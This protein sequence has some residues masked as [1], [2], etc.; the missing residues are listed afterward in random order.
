DRAQ[1]HGLW[2][3]YMEE[4][5][6]N[7]ANVATGDMSL[8]DATDLDK[9]IDTF[10]GL[11]PTSVLFGAIGVGG[12]AYERYQNRKNMN[13]AFGQ[14]N[15]QQREQLA[16]LQEMAAGNQKEAIN[17]EV[18][19]FLQETIAAGNLTQEEKRAEIEYLFEF[20]K[21]N[22]IGEIDAERTPEE[23][24]VDDAE[25]SRMAGYDTT[26][27]EAMNEAKNDYEA[28]LADI[29]NSFSPES[30]A[31]IDANPVEELR[32]TYMNPSYSDEDRQRVLDYVNAKQRYDGMVQ[33][34]RDD[35]DGMIQA[36]DAEIDSQVN[37][38]TGMVQPAT[39]KVDNRQVHIID[40]NVT[41]LE[42]GSIDTANSTKDIIVRDAQTGKVE[43]VSPSAFLGVDEAMDPAALKQQAAENIR[44]TKAQQAVDQIDGVLPFQQGDTYD[45]VDA[46]GQPVQVQII[47]DNGDGTVNVGINGEAAG[48]PMQKEAVQQLVDNA[49]RA[50]AVARREEAASQR[51]KNTNLSEP[52][53]SMT[54]GR[55]AYSLNEE[56][57]VTLPDGSI[58]SAVINAEQ[59]ADGQYEVELRDEAGNPVGVQLL[60]ADQLNAMQSAEEQAEAGQ[61]PAPTKEA[62]SSDLN[63]EQ[64]QPA[65]QAAETPSTEATPEVV[66]QNDTTDAMPMIGE[67]E[68]MEPDFAHAT[69]QRTQQ[70][71]YEESGLEQ[72]EADD[73]VKD[74]KKRAQTEKT[75][76]EGKKPKLS[77]RGIDNKIP[78]FQRA[79]TEWQGKVDEAQRKVDYW[80]SVEQEQQMKQRQ[81]AAAVAEENAARQAAQTEQ[82]IKEEEARKAEEAA[83]AAEQAAVGANNVN[84]AIREKWNAAPKVEGNSDE[85][86]LAN[87]ERIPGRYVLV[88]SGAASASHN[89]LNGFLPTEGFPVDENG[90]SVN[91]RDYERDTD[92]QDITRRIADSYDQRALQTPVVVSSDGVVLSGNGRT[93]A[94]ELAAAQNTDQAYT[95]YL[96]SHPERFGFTTEQVSQMQHPRV[97]FV[98]DGQMPYTAETFGKFNQQELKGQSK[99]EQAVKLGKVVD[100]QTFGRI[101]RGIN[102]FDS[103]GAYYND[104]AAATEAVRDLQRAGAISEAQLPQ[105]FDGDTLSP[106]GR[107]ILENTLIGKAFEGNPDA[108]RMITAYKGMRQSV[109][110]ALSE[111]AN[112]VALGEEYSLQNELANAIA[113]VYEARNKGGFKAGERV[114]SFAMQGNLFQLDEGATVADFEDATVLMLA[115]VLNDNRSTQLKKIMT[116]YNQHAA[117]SASGQMDIFS[118]GVQ[119]KEDI[120]NFVRNI[121]NNGTEAE[122]Q[123]ALDQ[124]REQRKQEAAGNEES[125]PAGRRNQGSG[126]EGRNRGDAQTSGQRKGIV[127]AEDVDEIREMQDRVREW[128]S[129]DY[130]N[131]ARG[132]SREDIFEL[133]DGDTP[134]PIAYVPEE[135]LTYLSDGISDNRIYSS[136]G[137]FIDHAVN[138]HPSIPVEQYKNIQDVL[139]NPD[140]V[141]EIM[142][143]GNRSVVFIKKIDK[144]NAV[145]VQLEKSEDGKIIWHKS[146]FD[147]RKEPYKNLPDLKE[148]EPLG[149]GGIPISHTEETAPGSNR[150][151]TPNGS[152]ESKDNASSGNIQE[153]QQEKETVAKTE[154]QQPN[155]AVSTG[156][157]LSVEQEEGIMPTEP[158]GKPTVSE[159]KDN[160][161][162]D[163]I[164]EN[165]QE[166]VQQQ[167]EAARKEVAQNP[168]EAQKEA[169]NY[170][171]GHIKLD[172]YDISIENPKGSTRSGVDEQGKEWSVTMNN[173]YGYLRG[174]EGVD[175]D[176][177]DVFLSDEPT[178]GNVFVV[179]QVKPDGSFDEHKVMYGFATADEARAAYLANY[180][181]GWT[182]LGAITE[183]SKDE[184]K[185]WV[186]S[187]HRKTKPFAEYKSVKPIS[188]QNEASVVRGE[189]YTI[190]PTIYKKKSGGMLDMQLVKFDKLTPEQKKTL[191]GLARQMKG[192]WSREDEGFLMRSME[193]A[194]SLTK[195]VQDPTQEVAPAEEQKQEPQPSGNKLVTDARYEELKERMR[196]KL[197][198]QMN[199]GIDPEILTI[200]IEM[201]V[202]HIEK[203]SRKFADYAKAM[204]ADLGDAIRPYLKAFY[205]GARDLPEVE[206][207]GWSTEMDSADNVSRFDVANFD[208]SSI[209]AMATAEEVTKEQ[210]VEQQAE[211]AVSQVTSIAEQPKLRPATEEDLEGNPTVYYKG[212][213]YRIVMLMR[214]G[215]QVSA[216]EFEKPR[217]T[218]VVLTNMESVSP[219]ELMVEDTPTSTPVD[220]QPKNGEAKPKESKKKPAKKAEKAQPMSLDLFAQFEVENEPVNNEENNR[221]N[222]E[223]S[224]T[225]QSNKPNNKNEDGSEKDNRRTNRESSDRVPTGE[226]AGSR[227]TDGERLESG[228]QERGNEQRGDN[229]VQREDAQVRS[230][231]ERSSGRI[232]QLE[233]TEAKNTRNFHIER[234]QSL[235]PASPK[236]RYDANVAAIRK[237]QDL[238]ESGAEATPADKKILAKFSGWGGLGA[239]LND[240]DSKTQLQNLLGADGYEQAAMSANSAFYTPAGVIDTLW[241]VAKRLGFKGGN[242]LEGSAGIGDII[243]HMPTDMSQRSSIEAVEIDEVTGNILKLLYPDAKVN[244]Q[245]FEQTKIPNGSVDL[246]ITNVPFVTGLKVFDDSGDKDLSK[247]FGN[248][249]DFCIAK[250][251]RKLREGGIG[252]FITSS[253]TMDRSDAL[254]AWVTNEGGSDFIGAFRLNNKT[255]GGTSVTSDII[256]I[257]KRVNG[258]RAEQAI[259]VGDV[260]AERVVDYE[261]GETKRKNGK[262]VPVVKKLSMLYNNYFMEHPENMAGKMDFGFEHGDTYRPESAGLFPNGQD[263][264]KMLAEWLERLPSES[265]LQQAPSQNTD[266]QASNSELAGENTKEGQLISNSKGEICISRGGVA[267]PLNLNANKIKGHTKEECLQAYDKIKKALSDVLDYQVNNEDD[268]GLKPLLSALNKA[269]DDFVS[270]Y[271]YLNRNTS[272]SFLRNDVDFAS[273]AALE[274][275]E[276][277]GDK[278]GNKVVEVKKAAVF[279][280]RVVNKEAEPEPKS[281]SEA[282]TVSIYKHGRLDVPYMAEKLGMEEDV[283]RKEIIESGLGFE[284]PLTTEL[285]VSFEYLS[286]NVREKLEQAREANED[287]RYDKNIKALEKVIPADIP[288]HLIEFSIG[289]SWVDPK[290]YQDYVKD[291]TGKNVRLSRAGGSWAMHVDY[292]YS[293][294]N[295]SFGVRSELLKKVIPGTDLIDAAM[296]NKTITV[297]ETH[298]DPYTGETTTTIDKDA[299]QACANKIDE[300]RQD[301]KDWARAKMQSD[302]DLSNEISKVYNDKFNN[303][304]PRTIPNEFVPEHFVGASTRFNL[305][306]HQGKAAVRATMQ[307]VLLAHEVGTGKTFT[308]ITAAMEMRRLELAKKPMIVVQNATT[309]QFAASAKDLY[310]NAK[311]LTLDEADRTAEGRKNFYAKIKYNDWDMIIVPQSVFDRIP[312]SEERQIAYIQDKIAEKMAVMDE[313]AANDDSGAITRQAQKEIDAL[314]EE[315]ATISEALADKKRNKDEK[316]A[317]KTRQNAAVKARE[318]LDRE[319]DEVEN[320]DDMEIDA[321]LIDEAHE[322]KHLG[323]ATAMQRG[324]KGIDPS[325][326]KKA[327][328]AYL[329]IQAVKERKNG[330]NVVMATGTPISNTAAEIWTFMRYLLPKEQL[331]AYDIYYFDDFVRNFGNITQMLEFATNGRFK[332]NN[333]F[334][335]YSNLPELIRIWSGAADTVKTDE[336]GEVK[337][338]IPELETGKAQD[339]YLPQSRSLRAIMSAVKAELRRYDEMSGKEKKANSHIPLTMYGIAKAAA[340]DPRLVSDEAIDEPLSKTN[341]AV[342]ETL[343][344]LNDTKSYNGTVAIFCDN[345]QNKHTGFNLYEEIKRKLI[346]NGVPE[347]QIFIMRSGLSDKKKA[348]VFAKMNRGE[349]RVMLGS[350]FTLGTG[351]NIQERLHTLIH[352]DAPNRPMDY[353]QRNGRILRQGNLHRDWNK[354]VRVL[355]F[356]VEDSLDVT[357]YQRLKTKGAIADSVMNGK[358][359]M[360]NNQENRYI[361]EEEDVFGD[362]V[363]QL[364]GS[365]YAMLKNQAEKDY[366]KLLSKKQQHTADQIY[367]HNAIP[368]YEGQIKANKEI[369]TTIKAGLKKVEETFPDGKAK[370]ITVG[371]SKFSSIDGMADFIK[372]VVNKRLKETEDTLR[373]R[374][375]NATANVN[376]TVKVDGITFEVKAALRKESTFRNGVL[377]HVVHTDMTYDCEELGLE[378]VPVSRGSFRNAMLD[379]IGNVITGNDL[380]EREEAIQNSIER[381]ESELAQIRE[382]DGRPFPLEKELKAAEERVVDLTEKMQKEL[383]EKEAKYTEMDSEVEAVNIN[384]LTDAEEE[385]SDTA[386]TSFQVS[387]DTIQRR[388]QAQKVATNAV[389]QALQ[390]AGVPVQTVSDK[391]ALQMLLLSMNGTDWKRVRDAAEAG[392]RYGQ[393]RYYVVNLEDPTHINEAFYYETKDA[394]Q[395]D[396][397]YYNRLGWGSFVMLDLDSEKNVVSELENPERI[398]AQVE[399]LKVKGKVYG[400]TDGKTI[401][402]TKRGMNPNTTIHEYTHLWAASL[403]RT[404]PELWGQVKD[405]LRGTPVWADVTDDTNYRNIWNNEDA[406]ASEALSRISGRENGNYLTKLSERAVRENGALDAAS[407]IDRVRRALDF[408]WN[409]VG[410]HVFGMKEFRNI[411]QVTDRILYDLM[412]GEQ[413]TFE[414][415]EEMA[416]NV[417]P[418]SYQP[419]K[420]GKGYKVFVLKDGQLYPPMVANPNGAATPVG[421]WLEAHAA[422]VAGTSKTGR[423]QVKAGGKGTQGGSGTLAYRPGW[424]LGEIPYAKQFNRKDESGE[425][426]LFPNN[427]VW[428]EVEYANDVDYQEEARKEGTNENGKY[429][430]SLAGLKRV[431]ENGSYRYRTNPDPTT[432]EWIITGAMKVNRILTPSEVDAMVRAAGREPQKR[433]EGAVTDEQVNALNE[434]LGLAGSGVRFREIYRRNSEVAY[435]F[436]RKNKGVGRVAVITSENGYDILRQRGLSADKARE[437]MEEFKKGE[438]L[439]LYFYGIDL[440]VVFDNGKV[441]ENEIISYLWHEAGHR[442]IHYYNIPREWINEIAEYT[443]VDSPE[444]YEDIQRRYSDHSEDARNEEYTTFMLEELGKMSDKEIIDGLELLYNSEIPVERYMGAI[445]NI[446]RYGTEER[447]NGLLQETRSIDQKPQAV[448]MRNDEAAERGR[449]QAEEAI[450]QEVNRLADKLGVPV[451][452]VHSVSELPQS[453]SEARKRIDEGRMVK[454]WYN[455]GRIYVYVPNTE[456]AADAKRTMVHEIVAHYGLRKLL[457]KR[458]NDFMLEVYEHADLPIRQQIERLAA[459]Y[460]WD[461]VTATEE[462]LASLAETTNFD[463]VKRSG[464]WARIKQAF[465]RILEDMGFGRLNGKLT[466]NELRYLLWRSYD[467]LQ[468]ERENRQRDIFDEAADTAMQ[469]EL[470]V[471]DYLEPT[472]T[473]RFRITMRDKATVRTEYEK[474]V[475]SG[476]FQ[477][478]EAVQDSMRGLHALYKAVLGNG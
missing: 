226:S 452:I 267:E 38:G 22:A 229:S 67:G 300:I 436:A 46:E 338:K 438:S 45:G 236:A 157:S 192:W 29:E 132:L 467:N 261:T 225:S 385:D 316:R 324:V 463:E 227:S 361:E 340:I 440:I 178:E 279:N 343:R 475:Q 124:A 141:K 241:D 325:F 314:E 164:Q 307:P 346:A 415:G 2:A 55:D 457:G 474:M 208:K 446:I 129:E 244:V 278:K 247:R 294:K 4:V 125:V 34:V 454:G 442:V 28:A 151:S 61:Q 214:Q 387:E 193:D 109:V 101:L 52:S 414:Q 218:S 15:D 383:A 357:A 160:T 170:K 137:Y 145:V 336:A 143:D 161:S 398:A 394:A 364:S 138:H 477:F 25:E 9:N 167:I 8:K 90:Q 249:H 335:G 412:S 51:A 105:M 293:E 176:H 397:A 196:K 191:S 36:S 11:A 219:S 306:E 197:G 163:N 231:S 63:G 365:E 277:R 426:Q 262:E 424:H 185:K 156:S 5:Y 359:M 118:G 206:Q 166:N 234:G 92:A 470:G 460:D 99:S 366:K 150:L 455:N 289:S 49:R 433:Q 12:Y 472:E 429:Q 298:K 217:I 407:I 265:D 35:I 287:G 248:I 187:S 27:P 94:G 24:A 435:N 450:E 303:F 188:G 21:Q 50:Q 445:I 158:N 368:K 89:A 250:N 286:G 171:K 456:D 136:M 251:V 71:L 86:V 458:F 82:A 449:S 215:S 464:W 400:W 53:R 388:S 113:L 133:F 369:L 374:Y 428:A 377:T 302:P 379:I 40:G 147:Q 155:N 405:L 182:G 211:E 439:G 6:N 473:S 363:A 222:E 14:M 43:F 224:V 1:F 189:G 318:M 165:Q 417:A 32:L 304:V 451:T 432:D 360:N 85:M 115:D 233:P 272:I 468:R 403:Q 23:R 321:I 93:M 309:G 353:T 186:E 264:N 444:F 79:K 256:I 172:G 345:Y 83:K 112:N 422:P 311:V 66:P 448:E 200:G 69:P 242:V 402:L 228:L 288:A 169:G 342:E 42:D 131:Q 252:I 84:P 243:G 297:K 283:V 149:G 220:E 421:V 322:Y 140:S 459:R 81:A 75:K 31:A 19:R 62:V 201:A 409:W 130:L 239:F 87:G 126:N 290:L 47:S 108:V 413:L 205:N 54:E 331:Q 209:D 358:S 128:L 142:Q 237:M 284:N 114:S 275:Y 274:N 395:K 41:L 240:Y 184:F 57:G 198:G 13:R 39:L 327:Q 76:L 406:I 349:I 65:E 266:S 389:L 230:S 60:T 329:K 223:N 352:L 269:Y 179:D 238:M 273:I 10:L 110:T 263:Q 378:S 212:R 330:K 235:A 337:S 260:S 18:K 96:R 246:A 418:E 419:T 332:E 121:V 462:Y 153:N 3:E 373:S 410:T 441:S 313:I 291:R 74:M 98:P 216:T 44:Q 202:Y 127:S 123:A 399:F 285:E 259:N 381:K 425:K 370:T 376:Y 258:Q 465:Y 323:F 319:V 148:K 183:V 393:Q 268:K 175:G 48:E 328:G 282:V 384:S 333:R 362:T 308:M 326:S 106:Q 73:F 351:V 119:S 213:R 375:G 437:Y 334:A 478:R 355:R 348:E 315:L 221:N 411:G 16:Q 102:R 107:E 139:N 404:N 134:Y 254:R 7:F 356:G 37:T 341:K 423:P 471:G 104:T 390:N 382:R 350:T 20:V 299:T 396:A 245:G 420:T 173:D 120:I 100:D 194:E 210:E 354:P 372:D 453:E 392:R 199:L 408:F 371:N 434:Q 301:F 91:D 257:R 255:F 146:F 207:A 466:D 88:E 310:P 68:D 280:G 103:L 443:K 347:D 181:P 391:E 17:R 117:E 203:G 296:N 320:F 344:S 154:P 135:S 56:I 64:E 80:N 271:G 116:L 33:R 95:D 276:E 195:A 122:Q 416:F 111:I 180:S 305:R 97:V 367:V 386:A 168:T 59:N 312:D 339:I 281:V 70:Y 58:G 317:A 190:T 232:P 427:F 270:T 159:S 177:I 204:I 72:D 476:T 380:R 144:Y 447:N 401:Y 430:H 295:S 469:Y 174:T 78:R 77:D 461:F 253:G 26:E 431:P 152:T 30:I 292:G 162:S